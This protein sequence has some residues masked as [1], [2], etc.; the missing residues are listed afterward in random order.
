MGIRKRWSCWSIAHSSQNG[1]PQKMELLV[2]CTQQSKWGSAK[3][4]AAGR[5]H[6][7][8]KM[9]IRRRWSYWSHAHSSQNGDPQKMELLVDCT[10][11][12]KW[13]SAEDGATGR[14][15]TAVKMG[16]RKRWSCWSLAH[17]SQNGDPQKMELLVACTQQSKWG[18]A[19]VGAAGRMHTA[20]KWGSAKLGNAGRMHT[21]AKMGIRR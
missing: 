15:H 16:I 8:V 5:L 21:A 6:T 19:K 2:A 13:G 10:Q 17:S 14:M 7:A 18:P 9:G 3:D 4:G 20:V 12:S 11:Q 1:D